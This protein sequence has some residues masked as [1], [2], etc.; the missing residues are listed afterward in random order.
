MRSSHL[1]AQLN[2]GAQSFCQ[3][4]ISSSAQKDPTY[5]SGGLTW[6]HDTQHSGTKQMYLFA[7]LGINNSQHK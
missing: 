7:T 3:L 2:F 6:R 5:L 1:V 4:A